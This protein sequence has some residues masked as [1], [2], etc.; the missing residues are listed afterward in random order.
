LAPLQQASAREIVFIDSRVPDA[1]TLAEQLMAQRG[2]GRRFDIVVLDADEDGIVQINRVLAN[3][4]D[5]AAIH[6]ISHGDEGA[7]VIGR[8]YLDA[9]RL[10][11]DAESVAR[12]GQALGADGDLLLYGCDVARDAAGEAFVQSLASL[13]GADVAASADTTGSVSIGGNWTLE[14]ATGTIHTQLTPTAFERLQWEGAF[15]TYTVTNTNNTGAGS[16]RQAIIDANSN[17]GTDLIS[18][19]IGLNDANHVYYRD[20]G[21]AGFSAPVAT[22]LPDSSIADFDANYLAGTARSWYSIAL[23]G[24][25]LQITEAVVID[26]STQAG[27]SAS[28]GPIIEVNAAGVTAGEV[29]PIVLPSVL[30]VMP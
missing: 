4:H 27:Y 7:V 30:T 25:D 19:N 21:A 14:F 28:K 10:A 16:L 24:N 3:E 6:I 17:L 26:G 18:F 22:T 15:A 29:P 20:N 1:M 9:A 11:V 13:T 5:L 8:T 23:S 12:W 2:G